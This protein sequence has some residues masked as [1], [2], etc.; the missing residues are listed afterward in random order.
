MVP[1]T[2]RLIPAI[3]PNLA[4]HVAMIQSAAI[5]TN[6]LLL[7]V[8]QNL[9]SPAEGPPRAARAAPA[10]PTPTTQSLAP[11]RQATKESLMSGDTALPD[12]DTQTQSSQTQTG[13][14]T[15]KSRLHTFDV[16]RIPSSEAVAPAPPPP[17]PASPSRPL[18]PTSTLSAVGNSQNVFPEEVDL[19]DYQA[20]VNE[21]TVQF[22]SEY[23]ETRVAA[24][25]WLIMLHQKA[26][27]KVSCPWGNCVISN[28][29]P[30][31][32]LWM[33]APSLPCSKLYRI[34]LKRY[35]MQTL[36]GGV[37]SNAFVSIGH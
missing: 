22:L 33:T 9:P 18:S 23:E 2:P 34:I 4:H 6:K 35:V 14:T 5:R 21:L 20:T 30:R 25:K 7:S 16:T 29:T 31:S 37:H 11:T 19:F 12:S 17:P 36:F 32:S 1:F 8:I 24:L 15:T 13:P 3:L 26:P 10:S 28:K 27:K